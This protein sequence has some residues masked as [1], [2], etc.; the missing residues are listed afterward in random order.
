MQIGYIGLGALGSA[1]A[2]RLLARY[3]VVVWDINDTAVRRMV[4]AGARAAESAAELGRLCDVVMVCL[5]RSSDVRQVVLGEGGVAE[6]LSSGKMLIDQTSGVPGETRAIATQLAARGVRMLDAPVSGNPMAVA[7]GTSTIIASGTDDVYESVLPIL[8]TITESVH[9]CS[10]RVGD[11]QAMKLVNNTMNAACRLAT[12]ECVAMGRKMGLSLRAMIDVLNAGPGRSRISEVMLPA[13]RDGRQSTNFAM[14]LMLKDLNQSVAL[15]MACQAPMPLASLVRGLLQAGLSTL[16]EQAQL[17]DVVRLVESMAATRLRDEDAKEF[18][19]SASTPERI[20]RATVGYVGPEGH[21]RVVVGRLAASYRVRVF[22]SRPEVLHQ[23]QA[24]GASPA[25]DLASLARD[26]DVIF[27]AAPSSAATRRLIFGAGGLAQGLSAGKV[28]ITQTPEDPVAIRAL[29]EELH[30]VGIALMDAPF[31]QGI[32]GVE[33]HKMVLCGGSPEAYETSRTI[34]ESLSPWVTY[35]G[36]VGN[37][38]AARLVSAAVASC[39]LRI[40][41]EATAMGASCGLAMRDM[42]TV[43][44]RSSGGNAAAERIL[45]ALAYG[46]GRMRLEFG[47]VV[48]DLQLATQAGASSGAPMLIANLVRTLLE[49]ELRQAGETAWIDELGYFC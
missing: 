46:E 44:N 29:A 34:L 42:S 30:Q 39:S 13:I 12:L 1:L 9:R 5:P 32:A 33:D 8:R 41:V 27:V 19:A 49:A 43:I 45:P 4:E 21:G 38:Q 25:S 15:G 10:Q 6:G 18:A 20:E 48:R 16:G 11:A 37:G 23:Y 28:V 26:C 22:E 24:L 47:N 35:C 31:L 14:S 2:G 17:E 3:P 36:A 7:A 40:T